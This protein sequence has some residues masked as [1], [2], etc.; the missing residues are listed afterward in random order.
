MAVKAQTP[1]PTPRTSVGEDTGAVKTVEVRLPVTVKDKKKNLIKGLTRGDFIVLEDN[2]PQEVTF[3][4]DEK[5]NPPVYV[6]VL[7]DT[8]PST[9][10]KLAFSK[11]SA[12]NFIYTVTR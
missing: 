8:S 9:A 10:G 11:A 12:E 6:G 2:V 3:F 4:S 7:M 1:T 5:T